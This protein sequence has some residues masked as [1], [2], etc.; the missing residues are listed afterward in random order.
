MGVRDIRLSLPHGAKEGYYIDW[1]EI[2]N[3]NKEFYQFKS[4]VC[5]NPTNTNICIPNTHHR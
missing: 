3:L 1:S 2:P 4:I 5:A